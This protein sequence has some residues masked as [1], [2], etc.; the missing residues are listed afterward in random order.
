MVKTNVCL[1]TPL[2]ITQDSTEKHFQVDCNKNPEV[3]VR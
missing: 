1:E 2:Y 3:I